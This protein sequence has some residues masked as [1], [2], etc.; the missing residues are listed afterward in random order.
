MF[1][2]KAPDGRLNLSGKQICAMRAALPGNVSQR[3]LA[4]MLQLQGV[5][6]DKNA[7][8]QIECGKRFVTDLELKAFAKVF[9]VSADELLKE[10]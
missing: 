4:E 2:N 6:L 7:I 3:A 10:E 5:D 1:K 8:Q 9:G